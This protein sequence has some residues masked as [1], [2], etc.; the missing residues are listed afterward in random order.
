MAVPSRAR[1]RAT[2]GAVPVEFTHDGARDLAAF[3]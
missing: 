3:V 1:R 2:A